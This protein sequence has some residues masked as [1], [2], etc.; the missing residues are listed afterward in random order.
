METQSME[1]GVRQLVLSRFAVTV[2]L[3]QEKAVMTE[4]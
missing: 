4:I 1:M 3:K 2:S